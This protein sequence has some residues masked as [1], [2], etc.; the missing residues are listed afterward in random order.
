VG[1]GEEGFF[2]ASNP[3]N[4]ANPAYPEATWPQQTGQDFNKN[5]ATQQLVDYTLVHICECA[6]LL[7]LPA[8]HTL[9]KGGS[10]YWLPNRTKLYH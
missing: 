10:Y 8:A 2:D 9:L 4:N 5:Q 6:A 7:A 3:A 1:V